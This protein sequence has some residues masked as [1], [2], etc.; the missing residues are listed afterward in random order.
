M[1]ESIIWF[2]IF[3]GCNQKVKSLSVYFYE[4]IFDDFFGM[5]ERVAVCAGC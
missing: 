5:Y 4:V 2:V 3:C 1:K